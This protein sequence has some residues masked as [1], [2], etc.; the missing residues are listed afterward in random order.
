MNWE[1]LLAAAIE[2]R[3]AEIREV[4]VFV[5]LDTHTP[6]PIPEAVK[7]RFSEFDAQSSPVLRGEGA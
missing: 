6:R 5:D 1:P 7:A 2:A 3:R 4:Q